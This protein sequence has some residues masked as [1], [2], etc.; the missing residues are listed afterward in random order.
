MPALV[1][2]QRL[3]SGRRVARRRRQQQMLHSEPL[4]SRCLLASHSGFAYDASDELLAVDP[5]VQAKLGDLLALISADYES[6]PSPSAGYSIPE[7]VPGRDSLIWEDSVGVAVVGVAKPSEGDALKAAFQLLGSTRIVAVDEY[8]SGTVPFAALDDLTA[9]PSLRYADAAVESV[10]NAGIVN[11][12]SLA[13]EADVARARFGVDGAGEGA[14]RAVELLEG[15]YRGLEP[16]ALEPA[17]ERAGMSDV[18]VAV[19]IPA[20]M[21]VDGQQVVFEKLD[22]VEPGVGGLHLGPNGEG[23]VGLARF[24]DVLGVPVVPG[25]LAVP[26][27]VGLQPGELFV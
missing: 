1:S 9:V 14:A 19:V 17:E 24:L 20:E 8:V 10:S 3:Q 15:L 2:E 26:L 18:V 7:F 27:V 13:L 22:I 4:E 6:L 23:E 12:A 25:G 21:H 5:N 16:L 11:Q